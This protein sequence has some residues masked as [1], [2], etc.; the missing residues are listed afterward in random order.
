MGAFTRELSEAVAADRA[1]DGRLMERVTHRQRGQAAPKSGAAVEDGLLAALDPLAARNLVAYIGLSPF[2]ARVH[3][4]WALALR[5]RLAERFGVDP[6]GGSEVSPEIQVIWGDDGIALR[7][8][9]AEESL[10]PAEI[11]L[12]PE[13]IDDLVV[14]ALPGTA[15]FAGVF[16]ECA[17]PLRAAMSDPGAGEATAAG[18]PCPGSARR[19]RQAAGRS[20]PRSCSRRRRRRPSPTPG[21]SSC[22]TGTASSPGPG[23]RRLRRPG[24]G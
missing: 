11:A 24:R 19:R 14:A 10:S 22:S 15:L 1:G 8:P 17:A 18:A 3:A 16:R 4:P 12:T 23:G 9:E 2:G 5:A 7:L 21:R 13:E 20:S 6:A